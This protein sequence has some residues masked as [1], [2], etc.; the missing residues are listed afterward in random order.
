MTVKD[1]MNI[2]ERV[3]DS[4]SV[5]IEAEKQGERD[6]IYVEMNENGLLIAETAD[7]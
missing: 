1:L 6:E 5:S 7:C 2:L 4:T 3:D